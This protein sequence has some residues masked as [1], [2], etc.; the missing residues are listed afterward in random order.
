[1]TSLTIIN[2]SSLANELKTEKRL[3]LSV[4]LKLLSAIF[5][6]MFIFSP[7]DSRSKTM[8]IVFYF[9]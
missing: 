2:L 4:Y 3:T 5:Y 9:I 8:K 1:M 6:Q 7:N